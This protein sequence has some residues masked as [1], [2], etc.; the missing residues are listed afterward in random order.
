MHIF[1]STL[2]AASVGP[3]DPL[4]VALTAGVI[5][6]QRPVM[7]AGVGICH[8]PEVA[9]CSGTCKQHRRTSHTQDGASA[10]D[11]MIHW[12]CRWWLAVAPHGAKWLCC[13]LDNL[14]ERALLVC[15]WDTHMVCLY[16]LMQYQ[17]E[18]VQAGDTPELPG[19]HKE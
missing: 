2:L 6:S 14:W 5:L 15:A 7:M 8:A 11:L 17:G 12:G 3:I 13:A 16:M 18:C 4:V 9:C 1:P 10:G 19:V